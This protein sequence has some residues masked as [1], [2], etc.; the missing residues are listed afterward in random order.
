[1]NDGPEGKR[2]K[3][4]CSYHPDWKNSGLS[5]S[6]KGSNFAHCDSCGTDISI[7]HGGIHDIKRHLAT[8]KHLEMVKVTSSNRCLRSLFKE[9]PIEKSVTR[10]EVLFGNFIAEH[11]LSFSLA[12]HF[13]HITKAMF[14]DS[15]IAKSFRSAHTKTT[16]IA[17]G[18]L[19]PYFSEPVVALCQENPF[20]ILCDEGIDHDDKNF[21]I[22]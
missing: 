2:V 21:A 4:E 22:L 19:G 12:D 16:C 6:K 7:G 10:A 1:M 5:A 14:P 8:A 9:S 3:R 15:Q 13:T 18:A 11:N 17:T 20:S